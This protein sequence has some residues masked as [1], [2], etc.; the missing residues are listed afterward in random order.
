MSFVL[1]LNDFVL[2]IGAFAYVGIILLISLLLHKQE[3]ISGHTARKIVHFFAGF[4]C[5]I[6]PFLNITFLALIVSLTFLAITR[7]SGPK[8]NRILRPVFDLMAE[9]DEQEI[10]YLAGPFSYALSINILVFIFAFLPQ[11]F[12]FPAS[13]IMVMMISDTLASYFGTRYGKHKINIKYTKTVRSIEGS[14]ALLVSGF[15]LSL[16]G[17]SF[18]GTLFPNNSHT[19]SP[20]WIVVLSLLLALNSTVIEIFSPSNLDD[21]TVPITGCLITFGLVVLFFPASIGISF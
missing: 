11:F 19:I 14:L 13:S 16:F 9:K 3:K 20:F 12:F 10:G 15:L 21:L 17:F 5:F 2:L 1:I 18:F 6:V 8:S 7:L 4:S